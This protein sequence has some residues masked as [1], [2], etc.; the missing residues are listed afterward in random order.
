MPNK[1]CAFSQWL[2]EQYYL[3]C[4]SEVHMIKLDVDFPSGV[5]V[6]IIQQISKLKETFKHTIFLLVCHMY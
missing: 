4:R 5:S 3:I 2:K 6:H 1:K